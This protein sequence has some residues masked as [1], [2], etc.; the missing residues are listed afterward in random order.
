MS[1]ISSHYSYHNNR[2]ITLFRKSSQFTS[3]LAASTKYTKGTYSPA[4]PKMLLT[5]INMNTGSLS[6]DVSNMELSTDLKDSDNPQLQSSA[7]I[8]TFH[9]HLTANTYLILLSDLFK[10]NF[11]KSFDLPYCTISVLYSVYFQELLSDDNFC[12]IFY[13]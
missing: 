8:K 7:V 10:S 3:A 2:G 12:S 11:I 5:P 9:Y 1:V 13:L 4:I 6:R